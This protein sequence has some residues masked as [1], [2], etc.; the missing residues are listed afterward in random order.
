[1]ENFVV[2]GIKSIMKQKGLIQKYVAERAGLSEQQ[3]SDMLNG[4]KIIR[5]DHRRCVME[6]TIRGTE[7]ELAGLV[8]LLQ[9]RQISESTIQLRAVD[10]VSK[11]V[12]RRIIAAYRP[13]PQ[14]N[15]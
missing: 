5:V 11:E 14:E 6:I 1:M 4:R 10:D 15:E 7:K 12:A 3:F 2:I 13:A 8:S 9:D